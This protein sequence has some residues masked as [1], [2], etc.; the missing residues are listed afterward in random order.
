MEEKVKDR[1]VDEKEEYVINMGPQHPST[2]GVLRLVVSLR[3]EIV[4]NVQPHL[5][6]I[7]RGIE[8][9]C[10]SITYPQI[11]H[12]TD[13]M[14]YLSAHINNEAVC[15]AVEKALDAEISD[16]I[17]VIRTIMSE[18]TRIQSHQLWWAG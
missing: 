1:A 8:K 18:L 11:I 13:R 16:R 17:K 7:H 6:Y 5:G 14:D 3:G 15:L 9:M 4:K 2:H 10:E 12:L